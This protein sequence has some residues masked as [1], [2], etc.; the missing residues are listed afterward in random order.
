MKRRYSLSD[1]QR[2]LN[3]IRGVIPGVAITTD[4]MVGFPGE[5]DGEFEQSYLFCQQAG[6]AK[7]HVF[8]FSARPGTAAAEMP[9]QLDDRVKKE[10][11]HRMLELAQQCWHSF[12]EQFLGQTMWVLWEKETDSGSGVYSGLT[13]NYIRVFTRSQKSLTNKMAPVK[14]VGFHNQG[15]WGELVSENSS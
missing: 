9:G 4:I 13:D 11:S 14:L 2:A 10:R 5:T 6:F 12:C 8:P 1:Y 7:I 3:L 15:L